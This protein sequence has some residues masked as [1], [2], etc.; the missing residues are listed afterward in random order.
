MLWKAFKYTE[1]SQSHFKKKVSYNLFALS[2]QH[3]QVDKSNL[4]DKLR[5]SA[6]TY[7]H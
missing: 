4:L 2:P 5:L 3:I 1:K 6:I 7:L